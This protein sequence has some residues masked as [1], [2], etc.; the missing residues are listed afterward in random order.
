[1]R[2]QIFF[3]NRCYNLEIELSRVHTVNRVCNNMGG[4]NFELYI[5]FILDSQKY[6]FKLLKLHFIFTVLLGEYVMREELY[7]YCNFIN[8][9]VKAHIS[10]THRGVL[11]SFH[12]H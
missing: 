1:M 11:M 5:F 7:V 2:R 9:K 6:H 3:F 4:S 8:E 10:P 12:H